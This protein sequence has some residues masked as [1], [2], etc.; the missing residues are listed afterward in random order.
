MAFVADMDKIVQK[1]ILT[2]LNI[3]TTFLNIWAEWIFRLIQIIHGE[4]RD[5]ILLIAPIFNY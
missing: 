1:S 2:N 3:I 4:N 5:I